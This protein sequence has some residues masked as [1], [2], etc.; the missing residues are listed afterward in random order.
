MLHWAASHGK[1]D[2][3]CPKGGDVSLWLAFGF[4]LVSIS[5]NKERSHKRMF[6]VH[7]HFHLWAFWGSDRTWADEI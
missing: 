7:I 1:K 4:P 5:S 6:G 2:D 3:R